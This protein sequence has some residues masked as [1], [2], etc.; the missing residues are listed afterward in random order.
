MFTFIFIFIS[1]HFLFIASAPIRR[2]SPWSPSF[3]PQI[4]GISILS[5]HFPTPILHIPPWLL[6]F[7]SFPPWLLAF[8]PWFA[9]FPSHPDFLRSHPN[10]PHYHHSHRDSRYSHPDSPR[11][12]HCPYSVP[13]F[14]LPAF[15]DSQVNVDLIETFTA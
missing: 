2:F 13:R 12:H 7:K 6:G 3:P 10:F 14:D 11:S 1:P 4:P 5:P 8:L 9:A 15:A